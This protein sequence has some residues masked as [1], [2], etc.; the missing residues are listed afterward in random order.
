MKHSASSFVDY[1]SISKTYH[2]CG[3][4]LTTEFSQFLLKTGLPTEYIENLPKTICSI[5]YFSCFISYGEPDKIFAVKLRDI[6]I[7]KG[8]N[9]WIYALDSIPGE[10]T[11]KEITNKRHES[12]KM[13]LLCSIES[14]I[15][16]G[17]KKEIEEQIDEDES[18]IIPISL[19][20]HWKIQGLK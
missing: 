6:L 8:I 2:S 18:K 11:W 15:R 10:E 14:L 20:N 16:D 4:K 19:D 17:V 9:C 1:S 5:K 3:D 12:E 13:I 7:G